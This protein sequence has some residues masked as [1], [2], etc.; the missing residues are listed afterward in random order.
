MVDQVE[1]APR[2][3]IIVQAFGNSGYIVGKDMDDA[4]AIM[5]AVAP[6]HLCIQVENP[7]DVLSR[8]RNAGSI[9]VGPYTPIAAGDY[10]SGTNH[11]LPT[12]GY[13]KVCSGLTVQMFRKTSTI[14]SLTPD[15]LAALAPTICTLARTE[16]LAAHARS[17][18]IRKV[19]R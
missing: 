2:K 8:I 5:N 19:R 15:G 16:G 14:Q 11:V 7:M 6:E 10:A 3:D 9:F 17:V 12:S 4:I 18:E 13:A 1:D